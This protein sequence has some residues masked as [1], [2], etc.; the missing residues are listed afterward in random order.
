MNTNTKIVYQPYG[1]TQDGTWKVICGMTLYSRQLA[2][3]KI[4]EHRY[5]SKK[6]PG[7]FEPYEDYK[8]MKRTITTTFGEWEDA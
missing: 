8:I 7:L 4:T 1:K 2:A 5:N 6:H 3:E